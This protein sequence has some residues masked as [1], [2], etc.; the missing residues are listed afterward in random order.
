RGNR[1]SDGVVVTL[2][3]TN[4]ELAARVGSVREVVSRSF[5]RMQNDGFIALKG[6]SIT[7]LDEVRLAELASDD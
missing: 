7:I 6:R 1:T 2:G 3:L 5:T 4:S